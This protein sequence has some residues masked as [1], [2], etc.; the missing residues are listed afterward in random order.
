MA[1]T[2]LITG[3]GSGIGLAIGRLLARRGWQIVIVG[4]SRERLTEAAD[5]LRGCG[6]PRVECLP[7][8]LSDQHAAQQLWQQ[9]GTLGVEVDL[10]VNNAGAFAY[11]DVVDMELER[12]ERIV[13]LN[14]LAVC[15]LCR[16]FGHDM[17]R[18]GRGGQILNISSYA[19]NMPLA[20]LA[21][22]SASKAFVRNFSFSLAGELREAGV[23]VCCA[24][25]AGVATDLYGLDAKW[26]RKAVRWGVL[27]TPERVASGCLRAVER[28]RRSYVPGVANRLLIPLVR[29][30][31]RWAEKFLR[32]KTLRFQK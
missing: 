12:L 6:A 29:H 9:C 30:L 4:R 11:C 25:P 27:M 22:Y 18:R 7:L 10:L 16:L 28:G 26:Q 1:Q 3:G 21:A 13:Q 23:T 15:R 5:E 17:A 2:A 24:M 20:G 31:P 8:D 32:R 14:A 19:V